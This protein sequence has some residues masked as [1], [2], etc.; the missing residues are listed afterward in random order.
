MTIKNKK[1]IF[2]Y[3][4]NHNILGITDYIETLNKV[5]F[6]NGFILHTSN[7]ILNIFTKNYCALII[8]DEF[9]SYKNLILTNYALKL[10]RGKKIIIL[11]E[12]FNDDK[13][14]FN[15]FDNFSFE[16]KYIFFLKIKRILNFFLKFKIISLIFYL[17]IILI[18]TT[19]KIKN[20][21]LNIPLYFLK[22]INFILLI[23]NSKFKLNSRIKSLPRIY[24]VNY[25]RF[26]F[27]YFNL[28]NL[29][30]KQ[31]NFNN[32]IRFDEIYMKKRYLGLTVILKNFDIILTS[33]N[34]II[35]NN[36]L[37]KKNFYVNRIYFEVNKNHIE[38]DKKNK[39]KL[40]FSGQLTN[41]R[42]SELQKIFINQNLLFDYS[43]IK[44]IL[45]NPKP[46]FII[47]NLKDKNIC[48]LHIKKT[49]K[50]PFSSPSRYINSINKNEIPIIIDSFTDKES[51]FLT[52]KKNFFDI[53]N[54]DD[55]E[56]QI[57]LLNSNIEFYINNINQNNRVIKNIFSL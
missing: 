26:K 32:Q 45:K 53:N 48:S 15:S 40:S 49:E 23:Y 44:E 18:T 8:I 28:V 43:E 17:I 33:H 7:S 36:K 52:L 2:L 16:K 5:F 42:F 37:Y 14:T 31:L 19:S 50:W 11:T 12:F 22:F 51:E 35:I 47:K 34:N 25:R 13:E 4:G 54:W 56:D 39:I 41:Y 10:F 24:L 29:L 9:S 30:Y 20:L 27:R 21:I 3:T 46:R 1:K 38:I 57:N 6:R 55:F